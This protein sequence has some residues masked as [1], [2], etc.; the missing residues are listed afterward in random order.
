MVEHPEVGVPIVNYFG[1]RTC[2]AI[3]TVDQKDSQEIFDQ[4]MQDS[5]GWKV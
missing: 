5:E 2:K 4:I 3:N 1:E